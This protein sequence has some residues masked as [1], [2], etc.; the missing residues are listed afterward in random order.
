MASIQHSLGSLI[1]SFEHLVSGLLESV[2]A[3]LRHFFNIIAGVLKGTLNISEEVLENAW[4]VVEGSVRLVFGEWHVPGGGEADAYSARRALSCWNR[5]ADPLFFP[6][7]LPLPAN[8]LPIVLL[9]FGAVVGLVLANRQTTAGQKT[10]SSAKKGG[11]KR[12]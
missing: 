10:V 11:K 4:K 6:F 2:L 5:E 3:I 8:F 9:V 7:A 12:A 1:S